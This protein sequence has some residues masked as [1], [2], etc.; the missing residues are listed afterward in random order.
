MIQTSINRIMNKQTV[1]YSHKRTVLSNKEKDKLL[2]QRK[3][4]VNLKN[5]MLN[6]SSPMQNKYMLH[7]SI[8][9]KF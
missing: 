9:M 5:V 3:T 6:E 1:I 7:S 2:I 8:S 4:W